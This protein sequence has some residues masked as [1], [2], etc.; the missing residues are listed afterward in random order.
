[1]NI[2]YEAHAEGIQIRLIEQGVAS[3]AIVFI[4]GDLACIAHRTTDFACAKERFERVVE[5]AAVW[6]AHPA[7]KQP[8]SRNIPINSYNQEA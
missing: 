6:L 7:W 3:F 8:S 4:N 1:M 5:N 2:L